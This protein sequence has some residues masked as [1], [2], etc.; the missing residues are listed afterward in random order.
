VAGAPWSAWVAPVGKGEAG[1]G[2][3]GADRTR[4]QGHRCPSTT[5]KPPPRSSPSTS[6]ASPSGT[7]PAGWPACWCWV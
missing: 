4:S 5:R 7:A 6:C 2:D 1:T 3:Q